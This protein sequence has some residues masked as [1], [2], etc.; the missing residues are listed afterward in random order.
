MRKNKKED[1][2]DDDMDDMRMGLNEST[3]IKLSPQMILR[4]T[5]IAEAD[6]FLRFSDYQQGSDVHRPLTFE[7]VEIVYFKLSAENLYTQALELDGNDI[8]VLLCRSRCR[9]LNGNPMGAGLDADKILS[10]DPKHV[11]GI[12]CKADALFT[13]GDFEMAMVKLKPI[14]YRGH[15]SRP[16]V[17]DFQNGVSRCT[18]A[19]NKA[20]GGFDVEKLKKMIAFRK[21]E[22]K[23]EVS[24]HLHTNYFKPVVTQSKVRSD[25]PINHNL[26]EELYEDYVYLKE[27]EKDPMFNEA[28][29]GEDKNI[30][31]SVSSALD[32]LDGRIEF[33]RA[34]NPKGLHD[35]SV[36]EEVNQMNRF[37][38]RKTKNLS[39]DKPA[40]LPKIQ[41]LV[42]QKETKKSHEVI[43]GK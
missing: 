24:M 30:K 17:I 38:V 13:L 4:N 21:I 6:L 43:K 42:A 26:L 33:W 19:I 35:T 18:E 34:R 32:F 1:D 23:E 22:G 9:V 5:L 27:L 8:H 10:V 2:E 36:V 11:R 31:V 29:H 41:P 16:D 3:M 7:Q 14:K 15:K 25:N 28:L 12:I 40:V 20:M 39:H 37:I